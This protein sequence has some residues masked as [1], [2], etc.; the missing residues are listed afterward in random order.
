VKVLV[1][2]GYIVNEL[3]ENIYTRVTFV[4]IQGHGMTTLSLIGLSIGKYTKLI[5]AN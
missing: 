2:R 5:P 1:C 3:V 4:A